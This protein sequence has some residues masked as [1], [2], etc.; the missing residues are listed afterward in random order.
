MVKPGLVI[1]CRLMICRENISLTMHI[2]KTLYREVAI[3]MHDDLVGKSWRTH[4]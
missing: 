3:K 4:A 1:K 2:S